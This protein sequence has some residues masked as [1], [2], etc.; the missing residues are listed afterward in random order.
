MRRTPLIVSAGLGLLAL[1]AAPV[2]ASAQAAGTNLGTAQSQ[3]QPGGGVANGAGAP[4]SLSPNVAPG[5]RIDA[6]NDRGPPATGTGTSLKGGDGN[7]N[8]T[9]GGAIRPGTSSS[10][11]TGGSSR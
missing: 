2:Q 6:L 11:G 5:A 3:L 10:G 7:S 9:P 4:T 1:A 8:L